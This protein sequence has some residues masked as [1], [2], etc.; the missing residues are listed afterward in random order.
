MVEGENE[1]HA[2]LNV[3]DSGTGMTPEVRAR[4][5]EPFFTT[6][7]AGQGTG[8]GLSVV[9]GI[10][11]QCN[12]QIGAYSEPGIGTTFKIYLPT[13]DET[14]ASAS[15][16]HAQPS[17]NINET[18]LVV[19]DEEAV[20]KIAV[21]TLK[22]KGYH[23]L[24]AESGKQA[25]QVVTRHTGRID[26]LVTDVVMP[27][28]SGRQLAELLR[29]RL[30]DLKVLYQSG[31]TDDAVIRHGILEAEVAFLQKPYTPMNLIKKVREV[32]DAGATSS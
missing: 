10:I 29:A 30:P 3:S 20:R 4:I 7:P 19:E 17:P 21:L 1:R 24:E 27:E 32:L 12:G 22:S 31:Y 15:E 14:I 5:F 6:K 26:I 28:M 2:V 16:S 13:V 18:V 9:H 8:L 23:V 11:R 25:M